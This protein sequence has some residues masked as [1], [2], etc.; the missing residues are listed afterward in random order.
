MAADG[1]DMVTC[2][3]T[4]IAIAF[5]GVRDRD[6]VGDVGIVSIR[7]RRPR[8]GGSD[9][10]QVDRP[11]RP[12]QRRGALRDSSQERSSAAADGGRLLGDVRDTAE[13]R[14]RADR[15]GAHRP[16]AV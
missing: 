9:S 15:R 3:A 10:R 1:G 6:P 14:N 16:P 4:W 11:M 5:R 2:S 13:L 8:G 12:D 7:P